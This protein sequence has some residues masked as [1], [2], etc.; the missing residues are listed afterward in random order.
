MASTFDLHQLAA[1]AWNAD[2]KVVLVGDPAQ[3]G[4]INAPG[5]LIAV[6]AARGHGIEL[7]QVHRFHHEWE[8]Q[9]SLR[10]R[11]GDRTV[12]D[13]YEDAGR[14]HTVHDP[15]QAAA[16]VFAH[17]QTR[18]RRRRRGDDARPHPRRRRPT[19]LPR[20]ERSPRIR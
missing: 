1:T 4:T 11:D 6:L 10:L 7:N 12:I 16:Q 18:T 14:L 5:G 3:I 19:Q 9:A 15:D 17:W 2:A 8:A 20:Q 13:V